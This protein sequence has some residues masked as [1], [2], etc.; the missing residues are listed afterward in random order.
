MSGAVIAPEAFNSAALWGL[1]YKLA[2]SSLSIH[3]Q[4]TRKKEYLFI[5]F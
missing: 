5:K 2:I 4:D 3:L 1:V